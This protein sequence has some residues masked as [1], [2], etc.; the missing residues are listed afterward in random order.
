M[1]SD[2]ILTLRKIREVI[3][4]RNLS[5]IL[6]LLAGVFWGSSSIFANELKLLGFTS[7][8]TSSVRLT[9]SIPFFYLI[10]L[11]SK[12][13][14]CKFSLKSF[15]ILAFCGIFSV[16]AMCIFYFYSITATTAAVAAVLL[17]TAP[18][19]VMIMSVFIFK[20]KLTSK[21]LLCLVLAV[22]G[23]ALTSGIIGGI[24]GTVLGVLSGFCAGFC[25]SLYSIVSTFAIKE[26]NSPL[27]CTAVSFTVAAAVIQLL[28]S[29]VDIVNKV[30]ASSSP[31]FMIFGMI[32]FSICTCVVPFVLYTVGLTG[33]KPDVAAILASS[34]PVVAALVGF[35]ILSQSPTVFEI[36]GIVLVIAAIT[37]L[38]INPKSKK[39]SV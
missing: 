15:G 10:I 23:C 2:I 6:V 8:Q 30:T 9:F 35:F 4:K 5:I 20:E 17:Y 18:I 37:V 33:L 25:Y 22:A 16:L 14:E 21:K 28:T 34:E 39:A 31:L 36:I 12:N 11:F 26:G 29:P 3:M 13:R 7:L 1:I 24:K 19:F 38:N 32:L 27:V